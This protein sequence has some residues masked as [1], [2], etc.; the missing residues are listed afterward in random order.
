MHTSCL[1]YFVSVERRNAQDVVAG[2]VAEDHSAPSELKEQG[3][4]FL[5]PGQHD[6]PGAQTEEMQ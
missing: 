4:G 2:E 3:T 5:I 1:L 6:L